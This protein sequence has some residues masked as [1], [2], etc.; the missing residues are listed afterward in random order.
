[1][2][3]KSFY[4]GTIFI[5]PVTKFTYGPVYEYNRDTLRGERHGKYISYDRFYFC[6]LNFINGVF[7]KARYY[8][9]DKSVRFIG[10]FD[11]LNNFTDIIDKFNEN[12]NNF[13][14]LVQTYV[15]NNN[16]YIITRIVAGIRFELALQENKEVKRLYELRGEDYKPRPEDI[17]VTVVKNLITIPG[18]YNYSTYEQVSQD[19]YHL[20][21]I[22]KKKKNNF[23]KEK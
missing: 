15:P 5:H 17:L 20:I 13:F 9:N 1:M 7:D 8:L 2:L 18:E 23:S 12:D 10:K 6:C 4:N 14:D 19:Y 3:L 21:K 11:V 22:D 16:E